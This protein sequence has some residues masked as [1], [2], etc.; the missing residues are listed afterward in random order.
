MHNQPRS[1]AIVLDGNRRFA[2]RLGLASWKGHEFGL[3]KLE[4]LFGWCIELGIKELT[5]YCFSTE[6]FKRSKQEIKYLFALFW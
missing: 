5:L 6:N 2:R 1:I 4:D 3:Q